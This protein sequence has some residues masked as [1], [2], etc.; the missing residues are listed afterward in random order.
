MTQFLRRPVLGLVFC[1]SLTAA[2]AQ[3][4][5]IA[6]W[7]FE[8]S[9]PAT[10]GSFA[11]EI[12]SGSALGHHAGTSTYTSP[13]GNGS[14]HSFSSNTWAV[15]DYYQFQVSSLGLSNI[16]LSWDQISS[17]TGPKSFN[18]SYSTNG[19]DFTTFG[20]TYTVLANASPNTWSS[21]SSNTASSY[22]FDLSSITAI[23][24]QS[25]VYFRLVDASTTSAN[26]GTVA[27]AGTDRVDNF[28]ITAA[29]VPEPESYAM[30]L[31]GLGLMG[32]IAR[33]RSK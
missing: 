18:L 15:G 1:L 11:A 7:T 2:S 32:F 20:T 17:A 13:S 25:S 21:S 10:S 30:M 23:N 16:V 4:A 31:A 28:T 14:A 33:R 29:A 6:Q 9:Q 26:G 19:T 24:N 22:T 5:T 12:G 8:T 3:A 27:T